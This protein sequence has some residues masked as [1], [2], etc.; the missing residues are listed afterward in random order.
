[1]TALCERSSAMQGNQADFVSAIHFSN[2]PQASSVADSSAKSATAATKRRRGR[3]RKAIPMAA[4]DPKQPQTPS[5]A[6]AAEMTVVRGRPCAAKSR[7]NKKNTSLSRGP[8]RPKGRAVS[9]FLDDDSFDV[10][11][12]CGDTSFFDEELSTLEEFERMTLAHSRRG[13]HAKTAVKRRTRCA[14]PSDTPSPVTL[15]RKKKATRRRY[16][17][18]ATCERDYSNDEIEFMNALNEYKRSSG[19]M[20]PTCS[21]ILEVLR[22][23]GYE[24]QPNR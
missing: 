6:T 22:E 9:D 17:D 5:P 18:P 12:Y 7:S 13:G 15:P 20:F 3:P 11:V 19:R 10:D 24:K 23:L 21:E 2:V 1:M 4:F 8:K 16:I 14:E